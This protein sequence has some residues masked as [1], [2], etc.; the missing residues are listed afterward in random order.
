[1]NKKRYFGNILRTLST[2]L[3]VTAVIG[4]GGEIY[5][6]G[7]GGRSANA[8]QSEN[9]R[10]DDIDDRSRSENSTES[11]NMKNRIYLAVSADNVG[12]TRDKVR[13]CLDMADEKG[14]GISSVE[15]FRIGEDG[16]LEKTYI[17]YELDERNHIETFIEKN[18]LYTVRAS[19]IYGNQAEER[20]EIKNIMKR[21][22]AKATDSYEYKADLSPLKLPAEELPEYISDGDEEDDKKTQK[23]KTI[24]KNYPSGYRK[25]VRNKGNS[26]EEIYD[27]ERFKSMGIVKALT[28]GFDAVLDEDAEEYVKR[29]M[30]IADEEEGES[31]VYDILR[32]KS[33]T[34]I[35]PKRKTK[36]AIGVGAAVFLIGLIL[37]RV[38]YLIHKSAKR[39]KH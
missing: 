13:I 27:D 3:L 10:N 16:A 20:F 39:Q 29:I 23:R 35:D 15:C 17:S 24:R 2:A 22:A 4:T 14:I 12:Y 1:M 37:P 21:Q 6:E 7:E 34:L 30:E 11:E 9:S 19:D 31:E 28:E 5:A 38:F 25:I 36:T 8:V 18:G 33:K 32:G 26:M